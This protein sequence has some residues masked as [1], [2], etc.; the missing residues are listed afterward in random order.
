MLL[1]YEILEKLVT[2]IFGWDKRFCPNWTWIYGS[3]GKYSTTRPLH[4]S[5]PKEVKSSWRKLL[6]GFEIQFLPQNEINFN[7]KKMKS[8]STK[9]STQ[10][11]TS[12][13]NL[14]HLPHRIRD[15]VRYRPVS[16][17]L[18]FF[19]WL[20]KNKIDFISYLK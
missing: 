14:Y 4:P 2:Y 7:Q 9:I 8:T 19:V 5:C 12:L 18:E 1:Q 11:D 13:N 17:R 15:K 3:C 20:E 6:A 16:K 10:Y